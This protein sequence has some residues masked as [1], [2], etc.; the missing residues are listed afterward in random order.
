MAGLAF[1][2]FGQIGAALH[3][4]ASEIVRKT[5]FDVLAGASQRVPVDTGALKNSGH[6]EDGSS[7]L[8]KIV[9]YPMDYAGYVEYGTVHMAAQ[10][11]LTPAI[12]AARPGFEA[13]CKQLF[14]K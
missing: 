4:Q 6:V 7:D 5:A 12:E 9:S 10:P 13:A 3:K 8:E 2:H 14:G 11:Y 1:N